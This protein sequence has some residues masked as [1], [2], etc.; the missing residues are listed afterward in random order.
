MEVQRNFD[1]EVK[2]SAEA[3]ARQMKLRMSDVNRLYEEEKTNTY[4]ITRDMTRQYKDMQVREGERSE[5]ATRWE[6]DISNYV[7]R[8]TRSSIGPNAKRLLLIRYANF[9][10]YVT[11]S[12]S[13]A[14][15]RKVENCIVY[16]R[17]R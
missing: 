7:L 13:K 8:R 2:S 11:V 3:T 1:T 5:F 9:L 10:T 15:L 16:E 12:R 17:R 4:E 6:Y 14:T